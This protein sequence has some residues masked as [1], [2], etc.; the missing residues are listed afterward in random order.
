MTTTPF[1]QNKIF[2]FRVHE[3]RVGKK[4]KNHLKKKH[5]KDKYGIQNKNN[6]YELNYNKLFG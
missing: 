5:M 4:K 3:L 1:Q 2:K 6:K